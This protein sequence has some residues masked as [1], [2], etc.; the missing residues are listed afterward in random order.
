MSLLL[1]DDKPHSIH[2]LHQSKTAGHKLVRPWNTLTCLDLDDTV[3][4]TT[5]TFLVTIDPTP[6]PRAE[7][8]AGNWQCLHYK[9]YV[10]LLFISL[11]IFALILTLENGGNSES[12]TVTTGNL[13]PCGVD[14]T[15]CNHLPSGI[16]QHLDLLG[17]LA[18][19]NHRA[20]L[21]VW[22]KITV[23]V[24]QCIHKK[25][26]THKWPTSWAATIIPLKPP[27]SSMIATLFT[28]SRR[29]LTTQA[30]PT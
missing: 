28:F 2:W 23:I 12:C 5:A 13:V 20:R 8:Y 22:T 16:F 17:S 6:H 21:Q 14:R 11:V 26:L 19:V 7:H 9:Q 3:R 18:E 27:V 10:C 29:L 25:G 15:W 24:L 4:L 1:L 30:P